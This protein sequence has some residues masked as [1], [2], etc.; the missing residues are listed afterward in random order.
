MLKS[1]L[2]VEHLNDPGLCEGQAFD[3]HQM[4]FDLDTFV[5]QIAIASLNNLNTQ[6]QI[7]LLAP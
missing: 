6:P 3:E 7:V 4:F 2:S 5:L 1:V